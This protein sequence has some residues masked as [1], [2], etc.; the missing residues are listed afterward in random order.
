MIEKL[1]SLKNRIFFASFGLGLASTVA[2]FNPSQGIKQTGFL[3]VGNNTARRL[4]IRA[5]FLN[6][7]VQAITNNILI[8]IL[9]GRNFKKSFP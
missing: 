8:I 7:H 5:L 3:G 2:I 6:N 4:V 9:R 1:N